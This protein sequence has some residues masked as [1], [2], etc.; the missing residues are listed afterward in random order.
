MTGEEFI[1]RLERKGYS[2]GIKGGNVIVVTSRGGID[3]NYITSLPEGVVFKNG[4]DVFLNA[5]KSLPSGIEF[6]SDGDVFLDSL[7]SITPGVEFIN[8][9]HQ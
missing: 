5:L 3:L 1:E 6:G 8:P 9:Q 7:I 2:Y 4:G